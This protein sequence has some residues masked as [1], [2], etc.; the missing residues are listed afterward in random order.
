MSTAPGTF[1]AESD[2]ISPSWWNGYWGSRLRRAMS[3]CYDGTAQLAIY[4]VKAQAPSQAPYDA[5]Q[6]IGQDRQITQ[7]YQEAINNYRSRL[8]QWLDRWAYSGRPPGVLM[9]LRGWLFPSRPLMYEITSGGSQWALPDG[10]DP[11]PPG[12]TSVAPVTF[13]RV[14]PWNWDG[15]YPWWRSFIVIY[16]YSV[17]PTAYWC[18]YSPICG[19]GHMC[20]DPTIACG[21]LQPAYVGQGIRTLVRQ[22]QAAHVTYL[23]VVVYLGGTI[24]PDGTWGSW[25]K[26]VNGVSVPARPDNLLFI[27]CGP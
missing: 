1:G 17:V 13:S 23:F 5:I 4:A 18:Y 21:V 24:T 26:I 8:T 22:W 3:I 15:T 25:G 14:T 27:Y 7:G 16:A 11:M 6:W 12:A 10:F 20:G 9:A 19:D 2:S